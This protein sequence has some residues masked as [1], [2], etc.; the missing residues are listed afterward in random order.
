MRGIVWRAALEAARKRGQREAQALLTTRDEQINA[1]EKRVH[2]MVGKHE[3]WSE[4]EI[5]RAGQT[6]PQRLAQLRS[7]LDNT[8]AAAKK[9]Y[10]KVL[11]LVTQ[12]RDQRDAENRSEYTRRVREVQAEHD[13]EW[14]SLADHW[15]SGL[16]ELNESWDRLHAECERLFPDWNV[17]EY[18]D[19]PRPTEAAPAIEFGQLSLDLSQIKNGISVDE[20][21]R[22]ESTTINLPALMTLEEHPVLLITA[23]EEGR[24]EA[25]DVLQLAML[26]MITAMPPGKVRFTILDPVGLGENFASF[27]HLADFDEQLIASRIWTEGRQIDEQ[28]TRLTAHME[29]VLQKYLR[30]EFA[31]ISRIQC[32]GRRG[33]GA[34]SGAGRG[35]LSDELQR[36]G[37]AQAG[38]CRHERPTL[39]HLYDDHDRSQAEDAA[40]FQSV[41][42]GGRGCS[43][44]LVFVGGQ[45]GRVA[46]KSR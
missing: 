18:G 36:V 29:T 24:R 8:L 3:S 41:G 45:G 31:T 43:L 42:F 7:E 2:A 32:P 19:W 33:G 26:R 15:R 21:L 5:G 37:G 23:E 22:P 16:A 11:A 28:L 12:R 27:M 6:F 1:A 35:K 13:R 30:N 38:K 40:E 39:R 17:T 34:V 4:D 46:D 25:I 14:K 9:K 20:R 44:G 10:S